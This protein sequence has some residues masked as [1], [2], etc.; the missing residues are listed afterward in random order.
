MFVL[1]LLWILIVLILVQIALYDPLKPVDVFTNDNDTGQA[2][3]PTADGRLTRTVLIPKDTKILEI[4]IYNNNTSN[5]IVSKVLQGNKALGKKGFI[6]KGG[7]SLFYI[8]IKH[9]FNASNQC[10]IS[11]EDLGG[12]L[13]N[14]NIKSVKAWVS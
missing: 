10:I 4:V 3:T 14:V 2:M 8:R 1:L 7:F 13:N 5:A 12:T 6:A 9:K 11:L